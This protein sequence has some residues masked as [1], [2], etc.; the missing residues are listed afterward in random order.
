MNLES[1]PLN[2]R[3]DVGLLTENAELENSLELNTLLDRT[4]KLI[5]GGSTCGKCHVGIVG[6]G[7]QGLGALV[8]SWLPC[9]DW[10]EE[11]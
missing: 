10:A 11:W 3:S 2:S 5:V 9:A 1:H 8:F 4:D 6:R 7:L